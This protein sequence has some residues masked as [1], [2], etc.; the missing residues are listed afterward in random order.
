MHRA[1]LLRS[2]AYGPADGR[3]GLADTVLN[4]R[5]AAELTGL[6]CRTLQRYRLEGGGPAFVRLSASRVGY[7]RS[8]LDAWLASRTFTSTSDEAARVQRVAAQ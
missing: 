7:R 1:T 4:E 6:S 8:V 5:Q 3:A 2:A